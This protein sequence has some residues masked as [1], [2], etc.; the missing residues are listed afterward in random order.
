MGGTLWIP[1]DLTFLWVLSILG[2]ALIAT[3]PTS[4][5]SV[6]R[7]RIALGVL[8]IVA[9]IILVSIQN[10]RA[11]EQL[12][13]ISTYDQ[14]KE[15]CSQRAGAV[16]NSIVTHPWYVDRFS[17]SQGSGNRRIS[18]TILGWPSTN[19]ND[20]LRQDNNGRDINIHVNVDWYV[21]SKSEKDALKV[22]K[23]SADIFR[24]YASV[25]V[26]E[27][28]YNVC[29]KLKDENPRYGIRC[30]SGP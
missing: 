11:T 1:N 4:E 21:G 24:D 2:I 25:E 27:T 7:F 3:T 8:I 6:R 19:K 18:M 10:R 26:E 12:V 13:F 29:A 5:K 30:N 17:V 22:V 14:V 9:P 15:M 23:C 16:D 20:L 28:N